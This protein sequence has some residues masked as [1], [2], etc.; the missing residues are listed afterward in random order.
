MEAKQI[1]KTIKR[2]IVAVLLLM[3]Q[4]ATFA[5]TNPADT[6]QTKPVKCD[7]TE[8]K[9]AHCDSTA[10]TP[11]KNSCCEDSTVTDH[12]DPYHKVVKEK[13]SVR[14]G[15]F[16]VRHIKDD[17]YLEVPDSL[18]GRM[19][20]AVTRFTSTPQGF[21]RFSGEEVNH[22]AVYLEQYGQKSIFL[23]EYVQSHLA[24][25]DDRIAISLK[26][27]TADPIVYK[28]EVIG[29]NPKTKD[30]LINITKWLM[31]DNKISSFTASDRTAVGITA[32]QAD[33]TFID[34]I[35]TYPINVEIQT[36]RTYGMNSSGRTP[37]STTGS[38]TLALNTSIVLLP[39]NPMQPRY[40]DNRVGYF[41]NQ[42]TEFSDNQ[43]TTDHEAIIS[44]YRLEPKDPQAYKAGKL[45]EPKKQ[46]V[47]YIDPATPKKWVKYLIAG[48]NDWN[49]AF[50]AAGF[51]NAIIAKEFPENDTTMSIDDARFSMIRYLPSETENAYGPRIV[52]PR[53]GEIIEAHICWYHNVMNLV[54]K[55]YMTQCGPLD[56]RAQKMDFP[57]ELM[58]QLIRFVSSHEVGHSLGLRHNMIAS[59]ATPVEKLRDKAWVEK[60]GH[61][62]SI[63]DYARFNF[64]AQPEDKISEKGLF[65]RINDYDKWAIKWGYQYRP[66]FKDPAKEKKALRAEVTKV[67]EGNRRLWWSGDEGRAQDPRSQT[68]D[69][70]D[71]QMKANE[72]GMKNLKR[73]MQNIEKWTA[74]PDGQ[75]DDLSSIYS[76]C[77]QQYQRYANHVQRY[78]YGKYTNNAPGQQPYDVVP[79]A[80]Q[81]EAMQWIDRNVMEAPMWLYPQS[82][83]DKLGTDYIEEI[84]SR[85][86]TVIASLLAPNAIMNLYN[87][88]LQ[89]PKSYPVEEYLDDVFAMV[90]KPLNDSNEQMNNFRR[91]QQRSYVDF[92]GT[93][94]NPAS[95]A[96]TTLTLLTSLTS[97]TNTSIAQRSDAILYIE[98]H[99]DKV[100]NYL[101]A[102]Q[103]D[104]INALH[105]KNLLL[106]IKKIREKYDSGK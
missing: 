88:S 8:T 65:P 49:V 26:Q 70:G 79:K 19:M 34:S 11:K 6:T 45:V 69:L 98:Q 21:A 47:Y 16:T 25:P 77:R 102:Q 85:Q 87:T 100:E 97:T 74:Q 93:A 33:R 36:L 76:A 32:V 83:V 35:K 105:Y 46:I 52:D 58:G 63:M 9:H 13:G 57:D 90:W 67:L 80:L 72:Y 95:A 62:S 66:E 40:F 14:Y 30:Q 51:K 39:K 104:G 86:Q 54:K 24:K 4:Q 78:I 18:L 15:L 82:I 12:T 42:I 20:L 43:Q 37:A 22:S 31:S 81:K 28:F 59:Q 50:E 75:Y 38:V 23:R 27:S 92:L 7:T 84:R 60:Y 1:N 10:V 56:K 17:W 96:P 106:R 61:T 73:V 71:D 29:R 2:I 3:G 5:V 89:S 53:S 101:K 99:L 103:S 44:R 48:I 68:E 91:Q 64:V 94:L 55:W 41:N